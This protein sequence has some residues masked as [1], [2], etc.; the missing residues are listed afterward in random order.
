MTALLR[1]VLVLLF[2]V[3]LA[4]ASAAAEAH[5]AP[6]PAD[7]RV[8]LTSELSPRICSGTCEHG[9]AICVQLCLANLAGPLSGGPELVPA[10]LKSAQVPQ[11]DLLLAGLVLSP[12]LLP[13]IS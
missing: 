4:S 6:Y 13:P 7:T 5:G 8:T 9:A 1:F 11:A 3:F 10:V 2:A 12:R